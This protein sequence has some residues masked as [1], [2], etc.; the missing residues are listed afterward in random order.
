MLTIQNMTGCLTL[1]IHNKGRLIRIYVCEG[2]NILKPKGYVDGNVVVS[3]QN[4][5]NHHILEEAKC[6]ML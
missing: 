3:V 5:L 6:E 2:R 4:L 1:G